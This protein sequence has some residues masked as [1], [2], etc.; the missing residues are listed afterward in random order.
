MT[1]RKR[2]FEL[3][4][5]VG[6]FRLALERLDWTCV[7]ACEIDKYAKTVYL[8]KWKETLMYDD[9]TTLNTESLP[10]F[11]MLCAGFPCQSF[12]VAGNREGFADTRGTLFFE[13]IRII[14]AKRPPLVFLENVNGLLFHEHGKTFETILSQMDEVGY[15]VEWQVLNSKYFVPQNRERVFIIGHAR[16]A[17]TRQILP[18]GELRK[19]LDETRSETYLPSLTATDYKG[20]SKQR[21]TNTVIEPSGE[22]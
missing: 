10:N 12:S 4:S 2:F 22:Y 14:K 17:S 1:S 19:V 16:E 9:A 8:N 13:I 11:E 6:G 21:I 5:G 3:F 7:G 15:D 18:L 20:P